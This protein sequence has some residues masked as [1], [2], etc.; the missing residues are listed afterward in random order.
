M[1]PAKLCEHCCGNIP[2]PRSRFSPK[3]WAAVRFCSLKCNAAVNPP[4]RQKPKPLADRFWPK[5]D[6]RGPDEC[7]PWR[8]S[9]DQAGYGMV[10]TKN[11]GRSPKKG[12][13]THVERAHR[14]A[15]KLAGGVIPKG[16]ILC[17]SCY[18]PPCCN[19][20]HL[21]AGTY[22]DNAHDRDRKGRA[23]IGGRAG[24][25]K[26]TERDVLIIR[27]NN[28][29]PTVVARQFGVSPCV[30]TNIRARRSWRHVP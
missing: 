7:W 14:V 12:D 29:A 23:A 22:A 26:L 2:S 8:N 6:V 21:F 25:A 5:V 28:A 15:F 18:N 27:S 10:H 1:Y 16:L 9:C 17:H 11:S 20:A 24:N 4:P 19:P 3:R 13:G 30:I